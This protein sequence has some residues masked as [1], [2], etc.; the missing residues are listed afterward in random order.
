MLRVQ[1]KTGQNLMSLSSLFRWFGSLLISYDDLEMKSMAWGLHREMMDLC[2]PPPDGMPLWLSSAV[3][4]LNYQPTTGCFC[5]VL[6]VSLSLSLS[7][8]IGAWHL[9]CYQPGQ[10]WLLWQLAAWHARASDA[11]CSETGEYVFWSL[12]IFQQNSLQSQTTKDE[13]CCLHQGVVVFHLECSVCTTQVHSTAVS[14]I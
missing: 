10:P 7:L 13:Q 9:G 2:S 4:L 12:S 14:G 6:I 1:D 11:L 8:H 3:N 5:T